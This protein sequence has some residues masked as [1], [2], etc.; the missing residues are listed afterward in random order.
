MDFT[1]WPDSWQNP[2]MT[3]VSRISPRNHYRNNPDN[4]RLLAPL[5]DD[6]L[7]FHEVIQR[8]FVEA[9]AENRGVKA[10][11][12]FKETTGITDDK[13]SF[14]FVEGERK[15]KVPRSLTIPILA[16]F[17]QCIQVPKGKQDA[18][19]VF[20]G[21]DELCEFWDDIAPMLT[22]RV[23][24]YVED[25]GDPNMAAKKNML[26]TILYED[27]QRALEHAT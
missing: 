14:H 23:V 6:I 17:R 4:M 15:Y 7:A 26:W 24:V 25:E 21:F 27:V 10:N 1:K 5:F 12:K 11:G 9:Y 13:G 8:D 3:Y 2:V 22:K 20:D 19:W 18:G 16:A